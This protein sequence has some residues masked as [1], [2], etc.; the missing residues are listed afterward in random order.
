MPHTMYSDWPL[1]SADLVL[2]PRCD[3]PKLKS[4]DFQGVQIIEFLEH[5]GEGLYVYVFKV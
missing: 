1:S 2:L 4:F 5:V 3:G